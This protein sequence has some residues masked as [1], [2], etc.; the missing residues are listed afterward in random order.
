MSLPAQGAL[1]ALGEE[2]T[3]RSEIRALGRRFSTP[4]STA[5]AGAHPSPKATSRGPCSRR[6]GSSPGRIPPGSLGESA[7]SAVKAAWTSRKA[8]GLRSATSSRDYVHRVAWRHDMAEEH[9]RG[10]WASICKRLDGAAEW[11]GLGERKGAA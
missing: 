10:I 1:T 4:A 7:R 11:L 9:R 5:F 8:R 3:R 2:P 6:A